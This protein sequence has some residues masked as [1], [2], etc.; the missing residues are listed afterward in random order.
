MEELGRLG[1]PA[2]KKGRVILAHLGNGA[3]MARYATEEALTPAWLLR[4]RLD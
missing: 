1:D 4:R 2:A 3:S